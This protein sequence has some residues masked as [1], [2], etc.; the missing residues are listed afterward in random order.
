MVLKT[1]TEPP[2][3]LLDKLRAVPNILRVKSVALPPRK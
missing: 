2:T 1:D 3:A